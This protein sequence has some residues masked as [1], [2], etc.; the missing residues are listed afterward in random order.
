MN[1]DYKK[2]TYFFDYLDTGIQ[3]IVST[4]KESHNKIKTNRSLTNNDLKNNELLDQK[5][6]A[7]LAYNYVRD[8]WQYFPYHFSLKNEDWRASTLVK[9]KRGHCI[10]KVV[11]LIAI[12]RAEGIPARLGLAKV[13][14]HIA[15]DRMIEKFGNDVLVPHGYIEIYLNHKWIKATPAF[16]KTLC[17]HLKVQVLDFN[18]EDDSLFQEFNSSGENAFMEY[19]DDYGC[20]NEVPL[21][22][23]FK[24]LKEHYPI[25]VE[26]NIEWGDVLHLEDL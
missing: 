16:N 6:F 17:Q 2:E 24:L 22:F 3:K 23:M 1:T 15:V 8:Y 18:G 25:L 26:K 12:L 19:L 20:F 13:K 11:I 7:I 5:E 9:K 21:Q 14:N 10:D 4:I